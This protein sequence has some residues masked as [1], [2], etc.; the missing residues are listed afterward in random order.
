MRAA[1]A[2][3]A[4]TAFAKRFP[5]LGD[6]LSAKQVGRLLRAFERHD[7]DA[8]E[9]LVAEG[10]KSDELFLVWDGQLD[11]TMASAT[12]DRRLAQ[13]GPGSYFGEVSL[14]EPGPASASVVTEQG[15]EVL[16]LS[17]GRLDELRESDPEVAA[18]LLGEALRSLSERF[19]SAS[20]HLEQLEAAAGG[21]RG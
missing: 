9:A 14:F 7:A 2:R 1:L 6:E 13:L 20:A 18:A 8:G 5:Q 19:R 11:I 12:G 10:T 17:R 4:P 15:C 16:R 21:A 3:I